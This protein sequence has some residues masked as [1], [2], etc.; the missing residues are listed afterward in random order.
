MEI[1]ANNSGKLQLGIRTDGVS[2]DTQWTGCRNPTKAKPQLDEDSTQNSEAGAGFDPAEMFS[3]TLS[4]RSFLKF[5]NTHVLSTTTTVACEYIYICIPRTSGLTDGFSGL[6]AN[7][8]VILYVYVGDVGG[9][10]PGGILTFY[11][12]GV[13]DDGY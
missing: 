3:V 7:H 11:I 8:C 9:A 2:V 1:R 5:L 12:P 6:C 13:I 4:T 10:D